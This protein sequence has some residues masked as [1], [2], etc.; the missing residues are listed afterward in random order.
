MDA[1]L[2]KF[3]N[4]ILNRGADAPMS[5]SVQNNFVIPSVDVKVSGI[6]LDDFLKFDVHI[7]IYLKR[8]VEK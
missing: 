3:Q 6:T 8:R 2:D 1:N 7:L 5:L 4:K